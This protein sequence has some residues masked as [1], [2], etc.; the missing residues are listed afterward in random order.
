VRSSPLRLSVGI[1]LGLSIGLLPG[2]NT[3]LWGLAEDRR[4]HLETD[5]PGAQVW[6]NG[7]L[8]S[9]L[10]PCWLTLPPGDDH[11]L[12]ARLDAEDGRVFRGRTRA[13]C[14]IQ[15]WRVFWDYILPLGSLWV[16]IDYFTGALY[17]FEPKELLL[18]L[19]PNRVQ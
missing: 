17:E 7:E 3:V 6:V 9:E 15:P 4:V 11:E 5:P 2:C 8:W 1:L 16:T 18:Q 19:Q 13:A 14:W 10:T 12:R